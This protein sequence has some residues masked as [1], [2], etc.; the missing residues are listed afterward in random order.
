MVRGAKATKASTKWIIMS[1]VGC[2]NTIGSLATFFTEPAPD[3]AG[4]LRFTNSFHAAFSRMSIRRVR[5]LDIVER[6]I[7]YP[8][9]PS[10]T[11]LKLDTMAMV[12]SRDAA[13]FAADP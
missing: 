11:R 2:I 9:R 3:P 7:I 13:F 6:L 10:D 5:L 8:K 1:G 4:D 12:V